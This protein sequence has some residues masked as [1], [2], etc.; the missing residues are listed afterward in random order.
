MGADALRDALLSG[1]APD[2]PGP[3]IEVAL[4]GLRYPP[5]DLGETL[6]QQ[7]LVLEAAR[8]AAAGIELPPQRTA[9]LI[10]MG[11]DPR[12]R[13]GQRPPT[14]ERLAVTRVNQ[15]PAQRPGTGSAHR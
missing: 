10:G 13:P 6:G 12:D 9:V 2:Q 5:R 3:D 8:E 1:Q 7:V 15:G 4:D 14:P 11:C